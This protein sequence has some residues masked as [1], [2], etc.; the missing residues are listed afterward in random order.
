MEAIYLFSGL[1][2]FSIVGIAILT[3][4]EKR[5]KREHSKE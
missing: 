2:I 4:R 3:Y 5:Y 1:I